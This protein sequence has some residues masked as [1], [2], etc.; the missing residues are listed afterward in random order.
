MTSYMPP[1]GMPATTMDDRHWGAW[2]A[3]CI[4]TIVTVIVAPFAFT[5]LMLSPMACDACSA[6]EQDDFNVLFWSFAA[7]LVIPVALLTASWILPWRRQYVAARII[8]AVLAPGS[9]IGL[10]LLFIQLLGSVH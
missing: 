1:P 3:P 4:A 7:G 5:V 6:T 10:L 9:L 2:I 8:L